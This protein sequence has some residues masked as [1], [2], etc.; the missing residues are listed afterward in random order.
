MG[1]LVF[2]LFYILEGLLK[3][4]RPSLVLGQKPGK[5]AEKLQIFQ[6]ASGA[7]GAGPSTEPERAQR[8]ETAAPRYARQWCQLN[9]AAKNKKTPLYVSRDRGPR[10]VIS[11]EI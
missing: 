6:G 11:T 2:R 4:S 3:L 8:P 7:A 5:S 1:E 10:P 9:P